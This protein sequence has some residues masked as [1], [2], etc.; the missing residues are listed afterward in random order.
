MGKKYKWLRSV[1]LEPNLAHCVV[2]E[3]TFKID[4]GGISQVHTRANGLLHLQREHERKNQRM[5]SSDDQMDLS[6]VPSCSRVLLPQEEISNAEILQALKCVDSNISFAAANGDG[7][8]YQKMFPDS[9]IAEGYKQNETKIKYNIQYGIAPYFKEKL[10]KD[11]YNKP[12]SFKFDETTTSQVKKQYDGYVQYW[13]KTW[14][15][16]QISYCGSLFVDHCPAEKL[17]DHFFEF[18][19]KLGLN[20]KFLLHIGMDG[21]NVNL[22]FEKLLSQSLALVKYDTK[23]LKTGTCPLHIVHNSF[24]KGVT[25]LKF[26]IDQYA[27]DIH[28]FF[29][30]SAARRA[31]YKDVVAVTN[32]VA[33]Y[34][35]KHS[36]TRWVT[37]RK[38][39]VRLIEQHRNLCH[40]FLTFLPT[41]KY[42]KASVQNTQRYLRITKMLNDEDTIRYL[43]FIAYFATDFELFLTVFQSMKPKIYI[44]YSEMEKLLFIVMSKFVRS[45]HLVCDKHSTKSTKSAN[46]MLMIK[47]SDNNVIKPIKLIDIGTKAKSTFSETVFDIEEVEKKFREDC[48]SCFKVTAAHLMQKLPFNTI[49]KNCSFIHPLKRNNQ[50]SLTGIENLT[51]HVTEVL[52][53]V[54]LVFNCDDSFS[55]EDVC[56]RVRTEWRLYQTESIP[57]SAYLCEDKVT[58][59][60]RRQTS[61][62]EKAFEV[63]GLVMPK[64][65]EQE[66]KENCDI[67]LFVSY[68][69]KNLND[70]GRPK[71]PFL[72][73][74]FKCLLSLS[75]GNSAPEN[76]FSINK[77]LL[78]IHGSSL[79]ENT[80]EALRLV[81][82]GILKHGSILEVPITKEMFVSVSLAH[83]RYEEDL[84][85]KRQLKKKEEV[86]KCN[87]KSNDKDICDVLTTELKT[88]D[89]DLQQIDS[90]YLIA[91]ES[92]SEGNSEFKGLLT[93]KTLQKKI[94]RE[95]KAKLKWV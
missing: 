2:C 77:Y 51:A 85:A 87:D 86:E 8:R 75:H 49:I 72:C 59:S 90:P 50:G 61:Y 3:K 30:M 84:E 22:K 16:I 68:V 76:G 37:V 83:Q 1:T 18:V 79:H 63:A 29:K 24:R 4:G 6:M 56:D 13:S 10:Q 48:L 39:V 47:L 73:A 32:V 64:D 53:G 60:S 94:F 62:W 80:I 17:V 66:K 45:K 43:A 23:F 55:A 33:E 82:D 67:E 52:K 65:N 78:D 5:F 44:L 95:L 69:E 38:V 70:D 20:L 11:F 46:D 91:D 12:F 54:L 81:K 34:V 26:D 36:A 92:V 15:C 14:N 41:T 88:I 89:A 35:Q 27:I 40:Y 31:D 7:S 42:F 19:N 9:K 25:S 58:N 57:D 93:K 21:P 28:F 74:L 71:Y